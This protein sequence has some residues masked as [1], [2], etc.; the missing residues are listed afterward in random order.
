TALMIAA[1][2]LL[3]PISPAIAALIRRAWPSREPDPPGSFLEPRLLKMPED[4]LVA[5]L[6]ELQ[7]C[8]GFCVESFRVVNA[9]I[10]SREYRALRHVTLNEH[11]VNEIKSS[12]CS[13]VASLSRGYLSRRQA[14]FAQALNRC[15]IELERISDHLD[16]L[17][18]FLKSESN[19]DGAN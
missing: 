6:H 4:A 18:V 16:R 19:G 15:A 11:A 10:R 5:T 7:R 14:L 17:G 1:A 9:A 3:L 8:A 13:Y 2:V 12:V